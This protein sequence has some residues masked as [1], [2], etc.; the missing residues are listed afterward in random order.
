LV[1]L[2]LTI[3]TLVTACQTA[4]PGESGA[5]TGPAT[6]SASA[7]AVQIVSSDP[8]VMEN[9]YADA[10][11]LFDYDASAPLGLVRGEVVQ[12]GGITREDISYASPLGGQAAAYL[13]YPSTDGPLPGLILMHG[14]GGNRSD[15]LMEGNQYARLGVL[16]LLAEAPSARRAG[17]WI[18]FTERDRDEQIQL[19]VDLR[20]AVDVLIEVGA[21]AERIGFLGYSYGAAMGGQL[22][23]LESRIRG[24]VLDVGDGGL[25]SHFTG[26]G[27][28]PVPPDVTTDAWGAWLEAMEP[29]EPIYFIGHAAPGSLLMQSGRQDE[30]IP[31]SDAERWHEVAGPSQ[32]VIWYESSHAL[33]VQAWC[34]GA[35]WLREFLAF[36][37]GDLAIGCS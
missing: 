3:A 36:E 2:I 27:D 5:S 28:P 11:Q 9:K 21:D 23:G 10:F 31:V 4:S 32:E 12:T 19:I 24:F 8:A 22:A 26:P 29:I 6:Q 16:V 30:L 17:E 34:D 1:A 7:A 13:L 37:E 20:R 33:P 18:N 35:D 25:V 14:S 15:M